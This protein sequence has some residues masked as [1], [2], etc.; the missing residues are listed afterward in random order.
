MNDNKKNITIILGFAIIL[1]ATAIYIFKPVIFAPDNGDN[2]EKLERE[3]IGIGII[4][5]NQED[6]EKYQAIVGYLNDYSDDLWYLVPIKDYGSFI[7]EMQIKQIKAGFMGSAIAYKM[8]KENLAAPVVR[9]EKD[10]ISTYS[11]YIFSRKDSG[12]KNIADLKNKKFAYVDAYTSAGYF[13][14]R[15]LL[16][17]NGYDLDSFFRVASFLGSHEKAIIS[18]FNRNYDGGAA[19]D[20]SWI[21]LAKE[22]SKIEEEM[23]V[24]AKV[25]PFP[26]NTFMISLEF[27]NEEVEELRNLF[28]KMTDSDDGKFHLKKFGIDR[29]I[30]TKNEDFETIARIIDSLEEN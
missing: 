23:Q 22:N 26:D 18:V 3:K 20:L 27:G 15:Y 4:M 29:F 25:G 17:T 1:I 11:G 16:K 7:A 12:I 6:I 8:I 19:K 21:K 13:A 5:T 30:V 24:L 28:L 9:G 10:G 14:P 2:S